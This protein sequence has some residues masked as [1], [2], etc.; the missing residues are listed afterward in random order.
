MKSRKSWHC[1][2]CGLYMDRGTEYEHS[3]SPE[4][5]ADV[6]L[7]TTCAKEVPVDRSNL[8]A[9]YVMPH[10]ASPNWGDYNDALDRLDEENKAR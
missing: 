6:R 7:C 3:L 1:D 5:D 4:K 9:I 10:Y 8:P 2:R